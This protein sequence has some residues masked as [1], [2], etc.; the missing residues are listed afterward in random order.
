M[1]SRL[2]LVSSYG[3]QSLSQVRFVAH[4]TANTTQTFSVE[5]AGLTFAEGQP[6]VT[7]N[8]LHA[9]DWAISA[10]NKDQPYDMRTDLGEPGTVLVFA[11]PQNFYLGYGVFT[12]AYIDRTLKRV[13]GAPIRYA[14]SRNHLAIYSS[15]ET[16]T[17]R[18]HVESEVANGY[19]LEQHEQNVFEKRYLVGE[20]ESSSIFDALLGEVDV[21]VRSLKPIDFDVA[22]RN[23]AS[24][25]KVSQPANAVLV[26]SLIR[27]MIIATA[28]SMLMSRLRI[29]R[30]QGLALL[31]YSFFEGKQE[32][33]VPPVADLNEQ[34]LRMDE[35]GRELASS[36]LFTAELAWLKTYVAHELELMRVELEAAELDS[37][38]D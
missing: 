33:K 16:E 5:D 22:E 9:R 31:G 18:V 2:E 1:L 19:I 38:P 28:E 23:L 24:L 4:G 29:M 15:N 7:T 3:D 25:F 13:S 14:G 34:K 6:V 35:L 11:V 8:L 30:W 32:V 10:R 21:C 27:D 17:Q 20:F 26:P 12:T 37:I 36:S